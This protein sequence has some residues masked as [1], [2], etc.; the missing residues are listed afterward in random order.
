[1]IN[2]LFVC[3]GNAS[4]S[5][6]AEVLLRH[7]DAKHFRAYSAGSAPKAI[8]EQVYAVCKKY[9]IN[10][11][12]LQSQSLSDYQNSAVDVLIT[13]CDRAKRDCPVLPQ[14]QGFLH[15]HLPA[16]NSFS[17]GHEEVFLQLR[18]RIYQ[19]VRLNTSPLA[20]KDTLPEIEVGALMKLL[21]GEL[22]LKILMLLIDEK[23]LSVGE[24]VTV[25][26][27][28][29]PQ[30]SRD[31]AALKRSGL[32]LTERRGQWIYYRLNDQLPSWVGDILATLRMGNIGLIKQPLL[33]LK[34]LR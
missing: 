15:W 24:L 14:C 33:A 12:G 20:E 29:Q 7:I 22:R 6:L 34:A 2:V 17:N 3:V 9:G 30:I 31:L 16:P 26:V 4:R 23:S 18:R 13:L 10:S 27:V 32:L 25:L 19:F 8:D 1:M 21:S 11:E 5:Q 28:S